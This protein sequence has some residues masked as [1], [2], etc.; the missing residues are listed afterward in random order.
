MSSSLMQAKKEEMDTF[1]KC[2]RYTVSIIGCAQTG[3]LAAILVAEAGFK[4]IYV[5]ADQMSVNSIARGKAPFL[6][7]EIASK[8]KN[9]VKTGH[10]SAT[11]DLATA[12][13]QS[14]LIG[15][16]IPV[17]VDAK[18]RADYS[19]IVNTCKRI[20]P[21]LRRGSIVLVMSL[22]GIG[23]TEGL[24]KEA[25]ENTSGLKVG[26]D[27]GL[28]YSPPPMLHCQTLETAADRQRI[29]AA[30]DKTSL[31]TASSILRLVTRGEV[32]KTEN[33][34][35][36]EAAALFEVSNFDVSVALANELAVFCEKIGVDYLEV[37][38]FVN[39]DP[40]NLFQFPM[41]AD[42]NTHEE[43]YL[44]LED[45]E[46]LNVKLR[47]SNVGREINEERVKHAIDLIKD[48]LR[49]CG[50]TLRRARVALLGVSQTPN[51]KGPP[52]EIAG[53]IIEMLE[54]R[55]AKVNLYDPCLSENE[56]GAL[57][58]H[59]KRTLTESL[60]GAD[61]IVVL[62]AHD[63]FK[64]LKLGKLKLIMKKPAA[65]VDLQGIVDPSK[66]EKEHFIYRGLGRGVWAT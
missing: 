66:I 52:K 2:G 7:N 5:D 36:A 34:R 19:T 13:S 54:A 26:T 50:K 23:I 40:V 48:A 14:D 46:S 45:A 20:G 1:E 28:A 47:I 53:E 22:T 12:V 42:E 11:S 55:G 41:F 63:Q 31:N 17:K 61:C 18:K 38:K 4:V 15:L 44:L 37:Q 6:R 8:L 32:R 35:T 24:I 65:I 43:S 39:T 3:I 59:F 30:T 16:A 57:R 33:I 51:G 9:H 21:N 10:L 27:F 25:L 49:N 60:E 58:S 62:T 29:V 64:H 56:M